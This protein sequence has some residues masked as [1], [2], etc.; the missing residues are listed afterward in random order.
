MS[1]SFATSPHALGDCWRGNGILGCVLCL[2]V[3]SFIASM[4]PMDRV[5]DSRSD[6]LGYT[7]VLAMCRS[8]VKLRIPH[9]LSQFSRNWCLVCRSKIRSIV[10]GCCAPTARRGKV[11][12]TRV[13]TWISGVYKDTFTF[14]ISMYGWEVAWLMQMWWCWWQKGSLLV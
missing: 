2:C 8:V 6:G 1:F 10:A 3:S 12:R 4:W 13:V 7:E 9:C 14:F 11:W 5:L